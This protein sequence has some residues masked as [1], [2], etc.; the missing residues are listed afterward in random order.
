MAIRF[1]EKE[2][3]SIDL[4]PESFQKRKSFRKQV[5]RLATAQVAIFLCIGL[6]VIGI[7]ALERRA[8]DMAGELSRQVHTLRHGPDVVA[9]AYARDI[10]RRIAAEDAFLASRAPAAFDPNWMTAI[11]QASGGEMAILHYSGTGIVITGFSLDIAAVEAHRQEVL[12]TGLFGYVG[13]GQI[14]LQDDGRYLYE[15]RVRLP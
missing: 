13:L 8:W 14:N 3:T 12:G 11:M 9:A 7:H 4:L 1:L 5:I 15:L 10:I 2:N 6:A